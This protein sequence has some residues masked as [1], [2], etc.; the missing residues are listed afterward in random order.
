M[1]WFI[2]H[3]AYEDKKIYLKSVN[4]RINLKRGQ[5]AY[6]QKQLQ[7]EFGATRSQIRENQES[8]KN[9]EFTTNKTTNKY[10]IAT[11]L[12]YDKYQLQPGHQQPTEQPTSNQQATNHPL[13]KYN[14]YNKRAGENIPSEEEKQRV[15]DRARR[16]I[17]R[18]EAY[19]E[20]AKDIITPDKLPSS[21]DLKAKLRAKAKDQ[22]VNFKL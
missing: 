2:D 4:A 20:G 12:N 8:M 3:A 15:A 14:K 9:M 11:I 19:I 1:D 18:T 17:A 10:T 16:E 5:L 21:D 6:T 22:D 13:N 7:E